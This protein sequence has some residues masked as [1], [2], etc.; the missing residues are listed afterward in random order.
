MV[1][2]EQELIEAARALLR[3]GHVEKCD[4]HLRGVL[5][6]SMPSRYVAEALLVQSGVR[7]EQGRFADAAAAIESAKLHVVASDVDSQVELYYYVAS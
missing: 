3:F 4:T 6:R 5:E 7:A 1:A 2:P